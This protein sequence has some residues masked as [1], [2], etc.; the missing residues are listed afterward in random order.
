MSRPHR[1]LVFDV[2]R[3]SI[4]DGPGIR[5]VVFFKGCGLACADLGWS[6]TAGV[7]NSDNANR[8]ETGKVDDTYDSDF[9]ASGTASLVFGIVPERFLW[10]IEDTFGQL[11]ISQFEP[12]TPENRQNANFF[13]T[14]PDVFL[15]L[16]SQ[17]DR[18]IGGRYAASTCEESDTVDDTRVADR[19]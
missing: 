4:H 15:R 7:A 2:Q 18:Q 12:V 17:T 19:G 3:F 8:V 5:T 14:D 13:S 9:V 6:V 16:G 10:T 11:T 1:A